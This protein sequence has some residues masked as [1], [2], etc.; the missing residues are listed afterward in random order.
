MSEEV[1]KAVVSRIATDIWNRADLDVASEVMV[2]TVKY[3]GSHMPNGIGDREN[4]RQAI[5]MYRSTS[6]IRT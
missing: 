2:A 3:H 1:N 5:A 4:W 6:L